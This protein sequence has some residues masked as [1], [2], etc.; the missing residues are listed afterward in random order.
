MMGLA[1]TLSPSLLGLQID[2]AIGGEAQS[3]RQAAAESMV[4]DTS[5]C[6]LDAVRPVEELTRIVGEAIR[7]GKVD[8]STI[9]QALTLLDAIPSWVPAPEITL[10][11][12]GQ[13]GFDWVLG[14]DRMLSLNVGHNGMLGFASLIRLESEYGRT[15]FA[16]ELP[17]RVL[18]LFRLLVQERPAD[19]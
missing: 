15:P 18:D 11:S 7:S 13:V 6:L 1:Q 17:K 8:H 2:T 19:H 5:V 4:A 16:G 9:V 12:D 14:R 10:E 3:L